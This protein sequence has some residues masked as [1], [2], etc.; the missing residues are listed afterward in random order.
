[1]GTLLAIAVIVFVPKVDGFGFGLQPKPGNNGKRR[2]EV[3][4]QQGVIIEQKG[5]T[6]WHV[7]GVGW[8]VAVAL[9]IV[10]LAL[11]NLATEAGIALMI[12]AGGRAGYEILHGAALIVEATGRRRAMIEAARWQMGPRTQEDIKALWGP[13]ADE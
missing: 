8:L 12:L 7:V 11:W 3:N 5:P 1:M 9:V 4:E 6:G 2:R 10:A 13:S